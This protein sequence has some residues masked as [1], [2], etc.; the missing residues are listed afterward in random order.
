MVKFYS[1]DDRELAGLCG[2]WQ[3]L[4]ILKRRREAYKEGKV[5]MKELGDMTR[6]ERLLWYRNNI[7]AVDEDRERAGYSSNY[8]QLE[9]ARGKKAVA[10]EDLEET[11]SSR[12]RWYRNGGREVVE[13]EKELAGVCSNWRQFY[14]LTRGPAL[15]AQRER[16]EQEE[17]EEVIPTRSEALLWYRAGGESVVDDMHNTARNSENWIQYKLTRDARKHAEDLSRA[18]QVNYSDFKSKEELYGYLSKMRT[19]GMEERNEIRT[20][21]RN[22]SV[23]DSV[24]KLAYD[25]HL[26]PYES[27]EVDE[28]SAKSMLSKQKISML[29]ENLRQTT[30]EVMMMRTKYTQSARE[31][32][33]RAYKE[34]QEAVAA[35]RMKRKTT[36]M[37]TQ[38]VMTSN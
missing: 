8:K 17:A 5:E 1:E 18:V 11:R 25:C 38:A 23:L 30:E 13:K 9:L 3:Q 27:Y 19:E 6:S 35:S 10:E 31:L 33:I 4:D 28:A 15:R 12:I 32:A 14:L 21:I 7:E 34:D 26:K 37:Q 16:E 2:N 29:E 24:T 20:S 22:R 36:T